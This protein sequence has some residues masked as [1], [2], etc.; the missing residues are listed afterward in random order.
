MFGNHLQQDTADVSTYQERLSFDS[1]FLCVALA[2]HYI[3]QA[4]L[5]LTEISYLFLSPEI[6]V[7]AATPLSQRS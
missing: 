4:G 7:C 2:G 1:G 6:K 5:K 3:D